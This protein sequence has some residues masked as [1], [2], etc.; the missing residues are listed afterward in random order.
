MNAVEGISWGP[1]SMRVTLAERTL[2]RT[3]YHFA[4]KK[5]DNETDKRDTLATGLDL[6]PLWVDDETRIAE[7]MTELWDI[8]HRD[9]MHV[10]LR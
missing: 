4:L 10:V 8:L 9:C 2:V 5:Y 1:L 3:V 7:R 6:L